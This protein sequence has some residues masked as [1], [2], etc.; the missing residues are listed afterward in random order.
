[1]MTALVKAMSVMF[2]VQLALGQSGA[3]GI[4]DVGGSVVTSN[5]VVPFLISSA[6]MAWP[7]VTATGAGFCH[8]ARSRADRPRGASTIW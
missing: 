6:G 5:G 4:G 3:P 8:A 7:P 1:V 2:S